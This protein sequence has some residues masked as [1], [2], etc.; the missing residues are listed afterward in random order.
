MRRQTALLVGLTGG[1]VVVGLVVG[2]FAWLLLTP[3]AQRLAL[4]APGDT[5]FVAGLFPAERADGVTFRW[6][7][8]ETRLRLHGAGTRPLLLGLRM[9]TDPLIRDRGPVRLMSADRPVA[10]FALHPVPAWRTYRILLPPDAVA[11]PLLRALPLELATTATRPGAHDQRQLGLPLAQVDG[12]PVAGLPPD[13]PAVLGRV[14]ARALLLTWWLVLLAGALWRLYLGCFALHGPQRLHTVLPVVLWVGIPV[15]LAAWGLALWLWHDPYTL[16]WALPGVL[17]LPG[18]ATLLLL[19]CWADRLGP[20]LP[21]PATIARAAPLLGAALLLTAQ[22]LV[23]SRWS[24]GGGL[25]LAGAG[26]LL[27]VL[28]GPGWPNAPLTAPTTPQARRGRL[29][30]WGALALVVLLALGLRLYRIDD[31]PYGLWRDEA[32]HGLLAL[33]ILDDPAYRPVYEPRDGV[34][35]PGLGFYPFALGLQLFGVH[36]WSMRVVTA[37]AGALTVL[38]LYGLV[39]RLTGRQTVALLAAALLAC[40]SWHL[41]ISRF[42]FPTIFDPLL[43]LSGLWLLLVA[44]S[45]PAHFA[46]WRAAGWRLAGGGL[47]GGCLG[48]AA[49][50]YH[51]GRIAPVLAGALLLALLLRQPGHWR[52]WLILLAG[53]LVGLALTVAPLVGYAL[54]YPA[55]FNARVGSVAL[56]STER[57]HAQAPLAVLDDAI[58]RHVLMFNVRGDSNSRHHA[59]DYP[60]LDALSGLGLLMGG[61]LLLRGW[62][63]WRSL[64]LLAALGL[65]VAPSLL[66]VNGPH[67]MRSIGAVAFACTIAALGWSVLLQGLRQRAG[68]R[69]AQVAGGA[70]VGLALLLNGWTYFGA[71]PNEPRV[72]TSFYPVHTQIGIYLRTLTAEEGRDALARVYVPTGIARHSVVSYLAYGLPVQTFEDA[73]LARLAEPG[74]RFVLSGYTYRADLADLRAE[75][76]PAPLPL[77][78]GLRGPNLP[79]TRSPSF[80][81]YRVPRTHQQE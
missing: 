8:P 16:A 31:L 61:A 25:A 21:R 37:L 59:P 58:G 10:T 52:R 67:A 13:P 36:V 74:A 29:V 14:L 26:I 56:L 60:L 33:R 40:S 4:G 45:P 70:V 51:T 5:R 50:T 65:T 46:G 22:V 44:W 66:A 80:V 54:R 39:V 69:A 24:V 19:A 73:D 55:T 79:G 11:D 35:L 53:L 71:M 28:A 63:D 81:V 57:L 34:D 27:L 9:Q 62:R 38:P 75:L 2:L 20:W 72:W 23:A 3:P 77:E 48:A 43:T 1:G 64:F 47:A 18:V 49:Q 41:T 12:L 15:A 68:R 17:W 30:A 76:A 78:P 42:S 32:R 6:S 7:G